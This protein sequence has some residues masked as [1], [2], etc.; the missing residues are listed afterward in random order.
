MARDPDRRRCG[1]TLPEARAAAVVI[2]V[3]D[4]LHCE[5][6]AAHGDMRQKRLVIKCV[7][8]VSLHS[9][10]VAAP[11]LLDEVQAGW[12]EPVSRTDGQPTPS[13][14]AMRAAGQ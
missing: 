10:S 1:E 13:C 2:G 4:E 11:I 9:C 12:V 8:V 5:S 6:H 7:T 3:V 14:D